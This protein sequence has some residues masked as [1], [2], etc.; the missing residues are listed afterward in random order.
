M[1]RNRRYQK[2]EVKVDEEILIILADYIGVVN[3][4]LAYNL[5]A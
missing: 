5:E 4:G 1:K 3:R 2:I